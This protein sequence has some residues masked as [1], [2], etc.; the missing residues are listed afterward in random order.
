MVT[1]SGQ[2]IPCRATRGAED[3]YGGC[4]EERRGGKPWKTHEEFGTNPWYMMNTCDP[5]I[6]DRETI[7]IRF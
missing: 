4:A 2:S 6:K 5:N 7:I 3:L 1:I